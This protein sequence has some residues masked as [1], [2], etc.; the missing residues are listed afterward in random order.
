[1]A[2]GDRSEAI[3]ARLAQP[4]IARDASLIIFITAL[5]ERATTKYGE[6]GYRFALLEAG[7]VG[8]NLALVASALDVA[9]MSVGGYFDYLIDELIEIDGITHSTVYLHAF[10]GRVTQE[11]TPATIA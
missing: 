1:M 4:E 5:F 7:H 3:S 10:G 9:A 2:D 6:R 11:M 8:Q